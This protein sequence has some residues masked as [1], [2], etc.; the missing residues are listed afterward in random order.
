MPHREKIAAGGTVNINGRMV[1]W[2]GE[3][4]LDLQTKTKFLPQLPFCQID[5]TTRW[6]RPHLII[7]DQAIELRLERKPNIVYPSRWDREQRMF[8]FSEELSYEGGF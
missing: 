5:E 2:D 3:E 1:H 7:H 8:K 4:L 6:S